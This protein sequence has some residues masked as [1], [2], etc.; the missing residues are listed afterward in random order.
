MR[1]SQKRFTVAHCN[2]EPVIV[3]VTLRCKRL[4]RFEM[5]ASVVSRVAIIVRVDLP[6]VNKS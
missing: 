2:V 5:V 1:T 3:R 4:E 6:S